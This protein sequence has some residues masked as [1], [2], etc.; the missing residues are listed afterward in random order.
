MRS[1]FERAVNRETASR[2][3]LYVVV[4]LLPGGTVVALGR[5]FFPRHPLTRNLVRFETWLISRTMQLFK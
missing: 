5:V 2:V 4:L 1:W 3:V